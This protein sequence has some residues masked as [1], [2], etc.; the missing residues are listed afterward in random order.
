MEQ[1]ED[2]QGAFDLMGEAVK[3]VYILT[4]P[5][6]ED[7]LTVNAFPLFSFVFCREK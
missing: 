1:R 2:L 6:K 3:L 4:S 7:P 5:L